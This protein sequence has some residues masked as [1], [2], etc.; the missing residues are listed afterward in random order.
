MLFHTSEFLFVFLP[1]VFAAFYV[2][3]RFSWRLAIASL[4]VASLVFY[5]MWSPKYVLLLLGSVAVNYAVSGV[6]IRLRERGAGGMARLAL[7]AGVALNLATLGYFKYANF[8]VAQLDRALGAHWYVA[9]IVLPIGISFYTFTQIAYLVDAFRGKVRERTPLT[10]LLFVSYFPH[11]VAGPILHHAEMVP[12]F[13]DRT[14]LRFD[15]HNVAAGVTFLA[16]GMFKK[17]VLADGIAPLSN[18]AFGAP[19]GT[20]AMGDAWIGAL[21]YTIQLYFDFSGYCDMAVGVSLL[22]N[23]KLPVNFWS[24]Y[25]ACSIIDFWRRWHITLSRFLRDYL[26]FPLGGNRRGPHWRTLNLLATMGLGGLWHGANWTFLLWGLLH[27]AY[28]VANH[29]Y[30]LWWQRVYGDARS[31]RWLR[32]VEW[33]L[34]FVAVTVGLVIF[35]SDG[36]AAAHAYLANMAGVASIQPSPVATPASALWLLA[37]ACAIAWLAPNS[38]EIMRYDFGA[39]ENRMR[40]GFRLSWR[41]TPPWG[42]VVGVLLLATMVVG[43][44][45]RTRLEFLYFQF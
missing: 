16:I 25:Q 15:V 31:P 33:G 32:L 29:Q 41:A 17:I 26:Y 20:L 23:I 7:G 38:N 5:A 11:L 37:A 42:C 28:L 44:T 30:R 6:I 4:A 43:V 24:P 35:R 19:H 39:Q 21:A 18:A 9:S 3:G 45:S 14:R 40:A 10:Y 27:G 12:Q 22:F 13:L 34:T 8:F 1:L 36:V 2:L